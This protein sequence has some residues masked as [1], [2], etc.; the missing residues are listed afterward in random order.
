[1]WKH[2]ERCGNLGG[3]RG[4][5]WPLCWDRPL[6]GPLTKRKNLTL[7]ALSL[8]PESFSAVWNVHFAPPGTYSVATEIST[9]KGATAFVLDA[10]VGASS[11]VAVPK[12][13]GGD[14][15]ARQSL[16][17]L[18]ITQAGK[19]TLTFKPQSTPPWKG[20]GLR[21]VALTKV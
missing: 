4:G 21:S 7:S 5:E 9:G 13:G 2:W 12:T 15:F 16:G 11:P 10:G 19:Q 14:T 8:L 20:L 17:A 3:R 18:K 1:M 6:C